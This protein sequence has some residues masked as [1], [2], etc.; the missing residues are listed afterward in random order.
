MAAVRTGFTPKWGTEIDTHLCSMWEDFTNTKCLGDTFKVSFDASHS[1]TYLKSGQPCPDYSSSHAGR[2]PPGSKGETGWQFVAQVDKIRSVKPVV[3]LLEMVENVLFVNDGA[4]VKAVVTELSDDYHIHMEALA[5]ASYGDCSN[6]RRLFIVGCCKDRLGSYGEAFQFP[7]PEFDASNQYSARDNAEPDENIPDAYWRAEDIEPFTMYREPEPLC[8]H[9]VG[10]ARPGMGPSWM[11]NSIQTHDG[12]YP[13]QTTHNGG[14]RRVPMSWRRGDPIEFTRL[15]AP[16]ETLR[17]ANLPDDYLSWVRTYD[18]DDTF[19][20]KAINMGI[21]LRTGVA[22]DTVI[23][24][25]LIQAGIP[26]DNGHQG[27][28]TE[29][30][31]QAAVGTTSTD[32][33]G[34]FQGLLRHVRSIQLDTC[35]NGTFM[36]TD[37]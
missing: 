23:H 28:T 5:V 8:I 9:R 29:C 24:N 19:V 30:D 22:I 14:G 37:M 17:I 4:E 33:I 15:T 35:A 13:T 6:R 7:R 27:E 34:D 1:V 10:Q 26:F 32:G 25:M 31:L 11:P 3:F 16:V 18:D 36:Y 12:I 20:F 21:P 2:N